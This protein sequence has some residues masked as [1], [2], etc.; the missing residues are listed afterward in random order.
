MSEDLQLPVIPEI[1]NTV[2][3]APPVCSD[4]DHIEFARLIIP[5]MTPVA[6]EDATLVEDAPSPHSDYRVKSD[7]LSIQ[8]MDF[9]AGPDQV[10]SASDKYTLISLCLDRKKSGTFASQSKRFWLDISTTFFHVF[11]SLYQWQL[12][13]EY[14]VNWESR[15]T[16][17]PDPYTTSRHEGSINA[18]HHESGSDSSSEDEEYKDGKL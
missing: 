12:C 6:V 17:S 15:D 10:L 7:S 9:I 14:M 2:N 11:H 4:E 1:T 5:V 3:N 18:H 8:S 16:N 13:R